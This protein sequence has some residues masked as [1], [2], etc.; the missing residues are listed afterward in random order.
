MIDNVM[1]SESGSIII[2]VLL[3]LGLASIFRKVCK[4]G[5]CVV[6]KGPKIAET[7]QNIYKIDDDCYKYNTRSTKCSSF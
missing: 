2:S 3:G 5:K 4:D 1:K 6:I 7:N